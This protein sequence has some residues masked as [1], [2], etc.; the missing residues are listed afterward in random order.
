MR[1]WWS[2]GF[3]RGYLGREGVELRVEQVVLSR[4]AILLGVLVA[5][6]LRMLKEGF[7]GGWGDLGKVVG[8]GGL[9]GLTL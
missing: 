1:I 2:W 5:G 6:Y 4:G 9:F 3:V 8:V 7:E